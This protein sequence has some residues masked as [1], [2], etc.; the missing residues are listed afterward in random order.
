MGKEL[1]AGSM[2]AKFTGGVH[3]SLYFTIF[4]ILLGLL[5][6]FKVTDDGRPD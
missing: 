2:T 5:V 4:L 3:F 6:S 1:T